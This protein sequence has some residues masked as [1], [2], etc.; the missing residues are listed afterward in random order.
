MV[1]GP[2]GNM[3]FSYQ[4]ATQ[5]G[6]GVINAA[7][8]RVTRF[9]IDRRGLNY[10]G[11]ITVGSD[12]GM[13]FTERERN[14]IGEIDPANHRI[15]EFPLTPDS[16]PEGI[17]AGPDGNIWFT[18]TTGNRIGEINP[19]THR[20]S[21]IPVP[22]TNGFP[23][24]ITAG[25]GRLWFAAYISGQIGEVNPSTHGIT[26]YDTH[27]G[28]P[29]AVVVTRDGHVWY[30]EPFL[31]Q[32]GEMDMKTHRVIGTFYLPGGS[33][34]GSDMTLGSDG[35]VWFTEDT[36]GLIGEIAPA[37][38]VLTAYPVPTRNGHP[39]SIARGSAG[40]LWSGDWNSRHLWRLGPEPFPPAVKT[41]AAADVTQTNA[42]LRG[43]ISPV[44]GS[45]TS[46]AFEYGLTR[47]LGRS[48]P[49]L[50]DPQSQLLAG[51]AAVPVMVTLS[52]LAPG[53][54]YYFELVAENADGIR[55]SALRTF[56]TVP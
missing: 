12:G 29:T 11:Q 41:G 5:G 34:T 3:W 7:T 22:T 16:N 18:E 2:H 30:P 51:D 36:I 56:R 8:S 45:R 17:T 1:L 50:H 9:P 31:G 47:A 55:R 27:A 13:W 38:G 40:T 52:N 48:V 46:W 23:V 33:N 49:Q 28:L 4:N 24:A 6:V 42:T 44:L 20:I 10:L 35:D 32:I 54:K 53:R 37:T 25:R 19:R 43:V 26:M 39:E 14:R 15:T 21:V